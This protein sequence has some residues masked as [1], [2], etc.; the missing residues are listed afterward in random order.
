MGQ[1]LP[2]TMVCY[3]AVLDVDPASGDEDIKRAYR[4]QAMMFHPDRNPQNRRMAERRF[5]LINE[6]YAHIK[7]ASDRKRYEEKLNRISKPQNDN[8]WFSQF[9]AIFLGSKQ[10]P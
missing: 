3:Y 5:R 6:A 1:K 10:T 2:D 7:T 9:A 4:K 8:S